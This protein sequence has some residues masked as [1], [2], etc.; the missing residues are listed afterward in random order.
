[1]TE[2]TA[3]PGLGQLSKSFEPA[4]IESRWGP[5]WEQKGF[6]NAGY[7]GTGE[8]R[9]GEPSFSIQLPPP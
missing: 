5:W 8:S 3:Q 4:A 1:M 9:A 6:A 2:N 7:R